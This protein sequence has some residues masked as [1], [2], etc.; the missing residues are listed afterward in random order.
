MGRLVR[1]HQEREAAVREE[2]AK[3]VKQIKATHKQS[4]GKV[5][6]ENYIKLKAIKEGRAAA[7]EKLKEDNM[8]E[9]EDMV[10]EHER[11]EREAPSCPVCFD[12]LLPPRHVYQCGRGHHICGL[13]RPKLQACPSRCGEPLLDKR[14]V[15]GEQ[16]LRERLEE[17]R[18]RREEQGRKK[19]SR[20]EEEQSGRRAKKR[21]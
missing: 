9:E 11:E 21:I 14:A 8:R 5:V 2:I 4:L 13:C 12:P 6:K 18:R 15:C 19:R 3:E 16:M 7:V 20:E 17:G 1:A 10:E